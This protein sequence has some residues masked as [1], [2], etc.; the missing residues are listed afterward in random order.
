MAEN[1]ELNY[2]TSWLENAPF[3]LKLVFCIPL[4]DLIWGIWRVIKSVEN[5]VDPIRLIIAILLI[6]PGTVITWVLD[7]IWVLTKGVG[8]WF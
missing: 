6:I 1:N 7:L 5:G 2:F 8:F 4:L 3:I